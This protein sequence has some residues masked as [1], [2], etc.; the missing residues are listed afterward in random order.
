MKLPVVIHSRDAAADTMEILKA[1]K[2]EEIGG[3]IHCFSYSKELARE[4]VKN[5]KAGMDKMELEKFTLG[6]LRRAVFEGDTKT[7][8]LMAGQV[9]GQ[10]K[11]IRTIAEI[12]EDLYQGSKEVIR[13]LSNP[14]FIGEME[15]KE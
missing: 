6:S 9:V 12:F 10:L 7:G 2:A 13:F 4:Y 3:V 1:H 5:E 11:E 14:D 15:I 8:S